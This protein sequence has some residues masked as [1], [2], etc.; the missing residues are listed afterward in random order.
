MTTPA[1]RTTALTV[2][3]T[4]GY[5]WGAVMLVVSIV[6]SVSLAQHGAG[7][8]VMALPA[9]LSVASVVSAHGVRRQRWP[10]FALVASAA[11]MAFLLLVRVKLSLFGV[12]VNAAILFLVLANLRHFRRGGQASGADA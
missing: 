7:V 5:T 2:A 8:A 1:T 4:L 3:S 12:A 9:V 6:V 11:W 10:W